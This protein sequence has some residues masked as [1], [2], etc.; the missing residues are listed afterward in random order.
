MMR[1]GAIA[2]R[3]G[4]RREIGEMSAAGDQGE[5]RQHGEKLGSEISRCGNDRGA[6]RGARRGRERDFHN[7]TGGAAGGVVVAGAGHGKSGRGGAGEAH[8]LVSG[9]GVCFASCLHLYLVVGV[10]ESE[11]GMFSSC[12]M[13]F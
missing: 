3:R 7:T 11:C 12:S 10:V 9:C 6:S 5:L 4:T 1:Y 2:S 13:R 8:W